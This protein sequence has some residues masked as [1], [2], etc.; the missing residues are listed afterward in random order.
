ML[1]KS[2]DAMCISDDTLSLFITASHTS[3]TSTLVSKKFSK[4]A[5]LFVRCFLDSYFYFGG[6]EYQQ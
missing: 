4:Q 1:N 5:C 2:F 6:A 3:N